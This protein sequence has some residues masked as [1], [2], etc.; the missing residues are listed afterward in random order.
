MHVSLETCNKINENCS[1]LIAR[2]SPTAV[3]CYVFNVI[4]SIFATRVN[5]IWRFQNVHPQKYQYFIRFNDMFSI[6]APRVRGRTFF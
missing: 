2:G 4:L 5:E 3:S 6:F 1:I